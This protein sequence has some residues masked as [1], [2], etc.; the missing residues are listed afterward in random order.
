MYYVL[1]ILLQ[2]NT[3][4][5]SEFISKFK[6]HFNGR[7]MY[8]PGREREGMAEQRAGNGQLKRNDLKSHAESI[9]KCSEINSI[10]SYTQKHSMALMC[11]LED[12]L[13]WS[14]LSFYHFVPEN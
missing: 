1:I 5:N 8:K 12:S 14:V 7:E 6:V 13:I 4:F 3:Q 11:R 10:Y 9:Y 2:Q